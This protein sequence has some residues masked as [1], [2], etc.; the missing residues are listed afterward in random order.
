[1]DKLEILKE[2]LSKTTGENF[3][4]IEKEILYLIGYR[5]GSNSELSEEEFETIYQ[6]NR[7][8]PYIENYYQGWKEGKY[9]S[10]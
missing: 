7:N 10:Q 1:M 9:D 2:Q 5:A 6:F 4:K 8:D 3:D